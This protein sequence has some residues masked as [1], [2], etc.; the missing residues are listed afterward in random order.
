[1]LF[2]GVYIQISQHYLLVSHVT[3]IAVFSLHTL[4]WFEPPIP[5][6]IEI[7]RDSCPL[8]LKQNQVSTC[9]GTSV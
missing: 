8:M 7:E 5:F 9:F 2:K 4:C 1:M 3:Q 6:P